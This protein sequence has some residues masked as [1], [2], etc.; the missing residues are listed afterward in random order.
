MRTATILCL[1]LAAWP[2]QAASVPAWIDALPVAPAEA[3]LTDLVLALATEM[4]GPA[5][6]PS[7]LALPGAFEALHFGLL[8]LYSIVLANFALRPH[9]LAGTRRHYVAR[10][11]VAMAR[12]RSTIAR[13]PLERCADR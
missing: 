12:I 4:P 13:R 3:A 7:A 2:V 8:L 9:R 10:A 6:H 11:A 5:T 1:D